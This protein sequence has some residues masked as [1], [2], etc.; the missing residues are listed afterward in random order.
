MSVSIQTLE[1]DSQRRQSGRALEAAL[2]I[3]TGFLIV[4]AAGGWISGSLALLADAGHMLHD[5]AALGL[6][7]FAMRMA[8]RPATARR[9][10]GWHRAEILA[11][12][13][14]AVML[15]VVTGGVL[16]EAF[17]RLGNPPPV[18][19]GLMLGVAVAG[20]A[21]NAAVARVLWH[22]RTESMNLRGA[23]LHVVADGLG[24]AAAIAA[25]VVILTTG[26]TVAD[27]VV[28]VLIGALIAFSGVRLLRQT[29]NVLLEATPP[30]IDLGEVRDAMLAVPGVA[31]VHDLHVWMLTSRFVALSAHAVVDGARMQDALVALR[32]T[33][34][35][36][37]GIDHT[38]IQMERPEWPD[39]DVHCEGDPRCLP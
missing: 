12:L 28:S 16:V 24:S 30:G 3:T 4:E 34:K 21:A 38:T 14:N 9:T 1:A 15:L 7:L 8:N 13:A 36:R 2:W 5:V 25:A 22:R 10:Y 6:A 33:L 11:A 20:L 32:E 27:P 17:R 26:W 39:E 37:F 18:R 29:L 35:S 19:P 23:F 31:S